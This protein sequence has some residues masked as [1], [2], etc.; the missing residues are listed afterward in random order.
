MLLFRVYADFLF[1]WLE[2]L[3]QKDSSELRK[4][5]E[6]LRCCCQTRPVGYPQQKHPASVG[7]QHSQNEAVNNTRRKIR[8]SRLPLADPR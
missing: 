5:R 1:T 3:G 7:S 8:E 6:L 2:C 4:K